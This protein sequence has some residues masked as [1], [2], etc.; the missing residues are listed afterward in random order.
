MSTAADIAFI[1]NEIDNLANL[2]DANTDDYRNYDS[3][4]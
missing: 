2:F 4:D 1:E 3:V